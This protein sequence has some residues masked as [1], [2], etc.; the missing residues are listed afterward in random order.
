MNTELA[1][2][3]ETKTK[4]TMSQTI[5][6]TK[7]ATEESAPEK[8]PL[9]MNNDQEG[10]S[11]EEVEKKYE[12]FF[13]KSWIRVDKD[14]KPIK[15]VKDF[16]YRV[17]AMRQHWPVGKFGPNDY[18]VHFEV[19]KYFKDQFVEIEVDMPGGQKGKA[20]EHK[21]KARYEMP[22]GKLLDRDSGFSISVTDFEKEFAEYRP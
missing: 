8:E 2:L 20:R 11:Y 1:R 6:E 10:L 9:W 13:L 5:A 22:S 7:P 4:T 17:L 12:H 15:Q 19:G 18:E 21:A 3:I 14:K 16:I